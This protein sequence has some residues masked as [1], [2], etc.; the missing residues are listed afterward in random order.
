MTYPNGGFPP[1]KY[2]KKIDKDQK[3]ERFFAPTKNINI[4]QLLYN[5]QTKPLI[6]LNINEEIEVIEEL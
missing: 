5:K 2:C 6:S 3:K 1:I 4:R